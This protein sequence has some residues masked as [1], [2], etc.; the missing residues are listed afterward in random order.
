MK[1]PL[2]SGNMLLIY[3][4]HQCIDL[5]IKCPP[6]DLAVI[7]KCIAYYC[8]ISKELANVWWPGLATGITLTCAVCVI[9]NNSTSSSHHIKS[10]DKFADENNCDLDLEDLMDSEAE[11]DE[12]ICSGKH[13]VPIGLVQ[14]VIAGE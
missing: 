14:P 1:A 12:Y 11:Q 13:R 7:W 2:G 9:S 6:N 8:D 4:G 3:H 5:V 10:L